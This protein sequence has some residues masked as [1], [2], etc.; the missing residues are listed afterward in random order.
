MSLR[1]LP[2]SLKGNQRLAG[3][4]LADCVLQHR[5]RGKVDFP[6]Q[7]I[8][9][10]VFE[11]NPVEQGIMARRVE[12][13]HQIDLGF[14]A[15]IA[16]RNRTEDRQTHHAGVFQFGFVSPERFKDVLPVHTCI[17]PQLAESAQIGRRRR[18]VF[19]TGPSHVLRR[20][21][22]YTEPI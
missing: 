1:E 2:A 14:G 13:G 4:S 20:V 15:G 3:G 5:R 18:V 6:P 12:F 10:S 21:V 19:G 22:P 7:Q 8:S 16:A 17:V 11:A 9:Q